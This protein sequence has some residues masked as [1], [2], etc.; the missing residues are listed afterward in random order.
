MFPT[1]QAL[2]LTAYIDFSTFNPHN[3]KIRQGLNFLNISKGHNL[4]ISDMVEFTTNPRITA[5]ICQAITP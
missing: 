1:H 3:L 5:C 2:L 4:P